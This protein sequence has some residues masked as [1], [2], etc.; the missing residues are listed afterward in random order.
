MT[1]ACWHLVSYD[2]R[3][4]IRRQRVQRH[5]SGWGDRI[6]YSVFRVH[7]TGRHI[8]R[9]RWELARIMAAEDSLIIVPI[10]DSVARR[11][12]TLHEHEDWT[13]LVETPWKVVGARIPS[14]KP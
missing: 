8:M 13:A 11:I 10:P 1:D 9:L 3:D 14:G 2:I 12:Q 7:G 5:L 6:Q 4:D